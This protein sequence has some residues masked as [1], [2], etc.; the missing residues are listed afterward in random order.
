[1]LQKHLRNCF[2]LYVLV[3]ILQLVHEMRSFP[4][5]TYKRVK[6]FLKK[7]SKFTDKDKIQSIASILSKDVLK[8]FTKL[9]EK[10][11]CWSLIFNKVTGWKPET[12]RSRSFP[13]FFFSLLSK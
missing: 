5:V 2:L 7:F 10:H 9:T 8:N 11:L 3:E 6:G 12:V 13:E 4:E 1:M